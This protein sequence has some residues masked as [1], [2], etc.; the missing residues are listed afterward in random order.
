MGSPAPSGRCASHTLQPQAAKCSSKNLLCTTH[1]R[2]W[3]YCC[4]F[5]FHLTRQRSALMSA[6]VQCGL[7]TRM[8]MRH[9]L[10]FFW[11]RWLCWLASRSSPGKYSSDPRS[12]GQWSRSSASLIHRQ[13]SNVRFG[14]RPDGHLSNAVI[15]DIAN[16][17]GD[18][19]DVA[20]LLHFLESF[21]PLHAR[22]ESKVTV[23]MP[24][25]R[26]NRVC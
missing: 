20:L 1:L 25:F 26:T 2:V 13:L 22:M 12:C 10:K 18:D 23:E 8:V 3:R 6:S 16:G 14:T 17:L 21:D 4:E 7:R 5:R 15:C 19:V 11:R 9:M 24:S